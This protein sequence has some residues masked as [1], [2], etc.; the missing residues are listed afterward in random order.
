[1]I[2]KK[3]G[4]LCVC[5]FVCLFSCLLLPQNVYCLREKDRSVYGLNI[6]GHCKDCVDVFYG[7]QQNMQKRE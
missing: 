5:L 1:M 6:T 4:D 2:H 7:S 3:M